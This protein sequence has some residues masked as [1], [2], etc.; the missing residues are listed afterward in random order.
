M[1]AAW[2]RWA[3][4]V[5]YKSTLLPD[6][7]RQRNLALARTGWLTKCEYAYWNY[8]SMG[9][10]QKMPA[11]VMSDEDV[12]EPLSEYAHD[13]ASTGRSALSLLLKSPVPV[14][15]LG[16]HAVDALLEFDE[17]AAAARI[18]LRPAGR[19]RPEHA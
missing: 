9:K 1:M 18:R 6:F 15:R 13:E 16:P 19:L 3:T 12:H 4:H 11:A 7:A 10:V 8:I 17:H 14:V 2:L 5:V